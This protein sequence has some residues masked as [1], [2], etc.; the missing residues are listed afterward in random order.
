MLPSFQN[1]SIRAKLALI[2]GFTIFALAGTRALGLAQL[3]AF[4]QRFDAYTAELESAQG[5]MLALRAAHR[6]LAHA[7]SGNADSQ[8]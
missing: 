3:G 8:R 2:L 4:L 7:A 6:A 1:L 5:A